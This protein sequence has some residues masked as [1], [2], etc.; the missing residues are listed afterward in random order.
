LLG[1]F[2]P[3]SFK[4]VK[5]VGAMA[6][7]ATLLGAV[8]VSSC[9]FRYE[10]LELLSSGGGGVTTTGGDA[11]SGHSSSAGVSGALGVG[12]EATNGGA[13]STDDGGAGGGAPVGGVNGTTGGTANGSGGGDTGG[14]DMGGSDTGTGGGTGVCVPDASCSCEVFQ[15]HDYRLCP[16][17]T[18]HDPG[19]AACQAVNMVLTHIDSAEENAWLLQQFIDHGMFLGGGGE[20]VMLGGSDLEVEGSW[21]WD[22][23]TLFWQGGPIA[24]VYNNFAFPPKT[25]PSDCLGMTSDGTWDQRACESGNATVACESP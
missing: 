3:L 1:S 7:C 5:W 11:A 13:G 9:R 12:A 18:T 17:L 25:G 15:G 8:A 14:S 24:D 2:E 19:A 4:R 6:G 23:G 20:I 21:R 16:V 22:D 10:Q